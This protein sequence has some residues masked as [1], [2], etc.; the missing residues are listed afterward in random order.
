M[1]F[2]TDLK[3]I[4]FIIVCNNIPQHCYIHSNEGFYKV[5]INFKEEPYL[6]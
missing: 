1:K 4:A 5:F 3:N 6:K 2:I